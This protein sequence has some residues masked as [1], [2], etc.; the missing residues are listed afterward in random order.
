MFFAMNRFKVIKGSEAEFETVWA[1][2]KTRLD[3]MPGFV[4][5]HLL[6]GSERDDHRQRV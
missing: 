3:E 1:S 2:R 5:F 4:I 6:R